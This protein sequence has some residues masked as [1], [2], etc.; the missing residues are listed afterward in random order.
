MSSPMSSQRNPASYQ[1]FAVFGG[2]LFAFTAAYT[3]AAAADAFWN[4]AS[5]WVA[6]VYGVACLIVLGLIALAN[7]TQAGHKPTLVM[8]GVLIVVHF[9]SYSSLRLWWIVPP[10][11]LSQ[12]VSISQVLYYFLAASFGYALACAMVYRD[13]REVLL[14]SLLPACLVLAGSWWVLRDAI[15]ASRVMTSLGMSV[16]LVGAGL[17][18]HEVSRVH[19][20]RTLLVR[21][22]HNHF[23]TELQ[24]AKRVHESMFP[25]PISAESFRF[26]YAYRPMRQIGGDFVHIHPDEPDKQANRDFYLTLIDVTGHGITSALTV[27][28]LHAELQ[29]YFASAAS[30]CPTEA[31]GYLNEYVR[32]TMAEHGLFA[33]GVCV[34]VNASAGTITIANAGHPYCYYRS[35]SG[36]S[37]IKAEGPMLGVFPEEAFDA[38]PVTLPYE[39]SDQLVMVTD[40]AIESRSLSDEP[41]GT[42]RLRRIIERSCRQSAPSVQEGGAPGLLQRRMS[43]RLMDRADVRKPVGLI[44]QVLRQGLNAHPCALA[45]EIMLS[46]DDF[47]QQESQDDILIATLE[48]LQSHSG[49]AGTER[50]AT[51]V[52]APQEVQV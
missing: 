10:K 28:R 37:E 34:K 25:E 36:L 27:N 11:E 48:L 14:G 1:T 51:P 47:I 49:M 46:I 44:Q 30:P 12:A 23:A 40:G 38:Q 6:V 50:E 21:K 26:G 45:D 18:L 42:E 20:L 8:T 15:D 17:V 43:G 16:A 13:R 4:R 2:L 33:T 7:T 39:A 19:S 3:L 5:P 24:N 52:Q 9:A 32:L 41:I 22:P 31:L 35:A 29:Q